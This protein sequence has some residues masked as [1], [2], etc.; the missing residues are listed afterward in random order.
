MYK[1]YQFRYTALYSTQIL[2]QDSY[3]IYLADR[4][5][6]RYFAAIILTEIKSRRYTHKG[7]GSIFL[8]KWDDAMIYNKYHSL[9]I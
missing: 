1:L 5:R 3:P 7:I 6:R 4:F 2:I 9:S 8:V